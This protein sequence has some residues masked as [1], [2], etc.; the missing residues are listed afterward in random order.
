MNL[1]EA[2]EQ[3][4]TYRIIE[5]PQSVS[6]QAIQCLVCGLT[7]YH[8]TDVEQRYCG[9]C[10]QFHQFLWLQNLMQ[11]EQELVSGTGRGY[12]AQRALANGETAYVVPLTF[13]RARMGIGDEYGFRD[14]Y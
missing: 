2:I 4:R 14:T 10:H 5:T 13:G 12:F 1:Q 9:Q 8:P 3:I 6:G 11:G 7:S